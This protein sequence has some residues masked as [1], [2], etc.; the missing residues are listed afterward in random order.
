MKRQQTHKQIKRNFGRLNELSK[1]LKL[2]K[3]YREQGED[4]LRAFEA[5]VYGEEVLP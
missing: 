1:M 5:I 2:N 4:A 3:V